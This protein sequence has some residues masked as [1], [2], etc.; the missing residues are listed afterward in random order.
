[1]DRLIHELA[2]AAAT[3]HARRRAFSDG[4]SVLNLA[5]VSGDELAINAYP[6]GACGPREA[7]G[8]FV[9]KMLIGAPILG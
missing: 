8:A 3:A 2:M 9:T 1:L 4:Q 7:I 6:F 5:G